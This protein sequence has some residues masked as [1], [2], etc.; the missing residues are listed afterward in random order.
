[1]I[2]IAILGIVLTAAYSFI[3][4]GFL[5][6][7]RGNNRINFQ[8]DIRL[9]GKI[10]NEKLRNACCIKV[11]SLDNCDDDCENPLLT[12]KLEQNDDLYYLSNNG[13]KVTGD[14]FQ[15][16]KVRVK[17]KKVLV[18]TIQF[19]NK[20]DYEIE[21]LLNNSEFA[22]GDIGREESMKSTLYYKLYD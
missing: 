1:M 2:V 10:I 4:S 5:N 12:I 6:F 9:V 19:E 17:D 16:I 20:P 15:D 18:F 13:R 11:G 22:A 14:I 7:S 3:N 21:L 8:N